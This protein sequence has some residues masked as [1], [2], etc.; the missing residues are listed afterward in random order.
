MEWCTARSPTFGLGRGRQKSS[1]FRLAIS[2]FSACDGRVKSAVGSS[3]PPAANH[4]RAPVDNHQR[5]TSL[6]EYVAILLVLGMFRRVWCHMVYKG[7]R[8]CLVAGRSLCLALFWWD[9]LSRKQ[10]NT[11]WT[12][13]LLVCACA[14]ALNTGSRSRFL[15]SHRPRRRHSRCRPTLD[16]R[17]PSGLLRP[18]NPASTERRI[19]R[20]RRKIVKSRSLL[21]SD[22]GRRIGAGRPPI[23][24]WHFDNR[25]AVDGT[26]LL[27]EARGAHLYVYHTRGADGV[28]RVVPKRQ[29]RW[30]PHH[31][32][33]IGEADK[34]GPESFFDDIDAALE[35]E[36]QEGAQEEEPPEEEP[37]DDMRSGPS[38][39][40][41]AG[42]SR[43]PGEST[44]S[45]AMEYIPSWDWPFS[46]P[47]LTAWCEAEAK[48]KCSIKRPQ[49]GKRSAR[50]AKKND[51]D[52]DANPVGEF[53]AAPSHRGTFKGYCYKA[54]GKGIGYYRDDP[55]QDAPTETPCTTAVAAPSD[56]GSQQ[57]AN[58]SN[59]A[60][61]KARRRRTASGKR[62]KKNGRL[63]KLAALLFPLV[64]AATGELADRDYFL[65]RRQTSSCCK[66]PE[67]RRQRK[68][69]PLPEGS[70]KKDGTRT[71]PWRRPPKRAKALEVAWSRRGGA[72][73]SPLSRKT[74]L[75][76][77]FSTELQRPTSTALSRAGLS[78]CQCT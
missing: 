40:G 42:P 65:R 52:S 26:Y 48:A 68:Q 24:R 41:G 20:W 38:V 9:G 55:A 50:K 3:T 29:R 45:W 7:W 10:R 39:P 6:G 5:N 58:A 61:S 54:G 13:I 49:G 17:K 73:E 33:R 11:L 56:H 21:M 2:A 70:G 44:F 25:N 57:E 37:Y 36:S 66:K 22:T 60:A 12:I 76:L 43:T 63:A 47:Q 62:L 4:T 53:T 51:R 72:Q 14:T 64:L 30:D 1:I 74:L 78:W 59:D 31:S 28:L 19:E 27:P 75:P 23:G 34:P 71:S 18:A 8:L 77:S 15:Y 32:K 16:R 69:V 67:R 35:S 46:K